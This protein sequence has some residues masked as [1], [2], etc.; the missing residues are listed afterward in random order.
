MKVGLLV[1]P[2]RR[3]GFTAKSVAGTIVEAVR[4]LA[5]RLILSFL[6]YTGQDHMPGDGA[7][8]VE[9]DPPTLVNN[10]DNSSP[11]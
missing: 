7:I 2:Q 5:G 8:S 4:W 11:I 6:P 9:L 10:E 1:T 3:T